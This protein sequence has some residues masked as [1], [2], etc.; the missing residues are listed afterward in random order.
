MMILTSLMNLGWSH[1]ILRSSFNIFRGTAHF[2]VSVSDSG[3]GPWEEIISGK[4]WD[5]R[6]THGVGKHVRGNPSP[7][8]TENF[9]IDPPVEAEYVRFDCLSW[10]GDGCALQYFGVFDVSDPPVGGEHGK[11][12]SRCHDLW[13]LNY[14]MK[15]IKNEISNCSTLC[16]S[17]SLFYLQNVA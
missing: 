14:C 3:R 6:T 8:K 13:K 7:A 5:Y 9:K 1:E 16:L 4:L 2:K 15:S 11:I 17:N 12:M 10:Y